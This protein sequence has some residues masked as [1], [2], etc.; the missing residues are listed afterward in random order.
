MRSNAFR[1]E[2]AFVDIDG[3][4]LWRLYQMKQ[5]AADTYYKF[6]EKYF[7]RIQQTQMYDTLKLDHELDVLF[8]NSA[9]Q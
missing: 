7:D 3:R 4:L 8:S 2:R 9:Q 1:L 5:S 6:L